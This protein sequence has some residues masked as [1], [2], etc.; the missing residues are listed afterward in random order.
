MT[1][2]TVN[3]LLLHPSYKKHLSNNFFENMLG[4]CASEVLDK[5]LY[6]IRDDVTQRI[7]LS[8]KFIINLL[9]R[10]VSDATI[11][12]ATNKL[13]RL[14]L[15]EK[16]QKYTFGEQKRITGSRNFY[17]VNIDKIREIISPTELA[18]CKLPTVTPLSKDIANKDLAIS[19]KV[20][21]K[22]E[23]TTLMPIDEFPI[24]EN[25][26]II[27]EWLE[28][29][30]IECDSVEHE[31]KKM[32]YNY[33]NPAKSRIAGELQRI[34][35]KFKVCLKGFY[36]LFKRWLNN[37]KM[38]N[39]QEQINIR[40]NNIIEKENEQMAK[41]KKEIVDSSMI[42]SEMRYEIYGE[43]DEKIRHLREKILELATPVTYKDWFNSL[44]FEHCFN[45]TNYD[46]AFVPKNNFI[47][48]HFDTNVKLSNILKILKIKI[49]A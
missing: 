20:V 5:L 4:R 48:D 42:E 39:S 22:K 8:N 49:A 10:K 40:L 41:S 34:G 18:S 2:L 15:I 35:Q 27:K 6:I 1:S 24:E 28:R 21:S 23:N 25:M 37:G 17:S 32:A 43:K 46:Y 19:K 7:H 16:D 38:N 47:K 30:G 26:P 33:T 31:M 3:Q 36:S 9:G 45:D 13:K 12:R 44:K 14:G 11:T 29:D